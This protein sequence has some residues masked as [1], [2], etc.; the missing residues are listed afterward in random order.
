MP[1]RTQFGVKTETTW[2]TPVV[3]DRFFEF[4][5]ESINPEIGTWEAA[6]LRAS[7]RGLREDRFARWVTGYAG[8]VTMP[9]LTKGWGIWLQHILGSVATAGPTDSTYTHTGTIGTLCGKGFTAQVNRPLGACGDTDQAF[10]FEGGKVNTCKISQE[11]GGVVMCDLDVLFEAGTTATA[12]ATA[13][14]GTGMEP[15]PWGSTSL[16]IAG[17]ATPVQ[18]WAVTV[19]NGLQGDRMKV[20]GSTQRQEPVETALREITFECVTD[21]ESLVDYNRVVAATAAGTLAAVVITANGPTLLGTTAYPGLTITMDKVRFDEAGGPTVGGTDIMQLSLK[22]KA[23]VP[24]SGSW[25][26]LA[27]RTADATA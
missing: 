26:S 9:V 13:S 15:L 12:L 6:A 17:T 5:S 18:S 19:N 25:L 24:V 23:L 20:R 16:T 4:D 11:A 21:F 8:S 14:Y 27:Y 7:T 1:L 10:T 3:V 22:G 2:G